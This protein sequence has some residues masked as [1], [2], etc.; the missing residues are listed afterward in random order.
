MYQQYQQQLE[1]FQQKQ[2]VFLDWKTLTN[3][4][5]QLQLQLQL[6][7]QIKIQFQMHL[8]LCECSPYFLLLEAYVEVYSNEKIENL[9]EKKQEHTEEIVLFYERA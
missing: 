1:V 6:Q 4:Q 2:R 7:I 3:L 5:R 9:T 8:H